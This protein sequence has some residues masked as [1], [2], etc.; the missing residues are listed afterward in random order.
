M[1]KNKDRLM[2]KILFNPNTTLELIEI[3]EKNPLRL[4][5]PLDIIWN[6][7]TCLNEN[8]IYEIGFALNLTPEQKQEWEEFYDR[9]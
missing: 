7:Y 9:V 2:D 4:K 1:T 6:K 3:G 5:A 8:E